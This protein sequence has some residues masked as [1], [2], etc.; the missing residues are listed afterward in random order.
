[1]GSDDL[2]RFLDKNSQNATIT[3]YY[4]DYNHETV[5]GSIDMAR[6]FIEANPIENVQFRPAGGLLGVLAAVNEEVEW[7]YKWNLILVMVSV[8]IMSV[9]TYASI[10]GGLIV[11]IP[12]IVSQPLSEAVMY[13]MGIDA[14]IPWTRPIAGRAS[15]CG[16][17]PPLCS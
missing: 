1:L 17:N 13:W 2:D 15:S 6:Q 10:V 4:K 11:M 9:L 7:S 3:V 12:S 5:V 14:N 8:F 16:L